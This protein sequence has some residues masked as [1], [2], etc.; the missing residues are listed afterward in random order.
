MAVGE[1]EDVRTH[2]MNMIHSIIWL[3]LWIRPVTK[4]SSLCVVGSGDEGDAAD[5][6]FPAVGAAD[7]TAHRGAHLHRL[8]GPPEPGRPHLSIHV[9][10]MDISLVLCFCVLICLTGRLVRELLS[11]FSVRLHVPSY[12]PER[13]T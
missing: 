7:Q 10:D 13:S 8:H 12:V 11:N 6:H 1:P 5:R 3:Y 4:R 2:T 9:S